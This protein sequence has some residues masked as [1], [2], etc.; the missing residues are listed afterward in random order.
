ME[1]QQSKHAANA[2]TVG[3]HHR[4]IHD[5]ANGHFRSLTVYAE[6]PDCAKAARDMVGCYLQTWGLAHAV[7]AVQLVVSELVGNV[8]HHAVPDNHLAQPGAGRRI[9]VC[10]MTWPEVLVL[11]VSDEDSTPPDLPPGDFVSPELTGDF[12]EALVPD[13]GRGLL[14][15]QRLAES[16]WWSSG[17]RGGK[18]VWSRFDLDQLRADYSA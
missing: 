10:L 5:P 6:S 1:A 14:I 8:V 18:T 12:V 4:S 9:D 3:A 16:V 11:G 15:A 17:V 7:D 13:R 2:S